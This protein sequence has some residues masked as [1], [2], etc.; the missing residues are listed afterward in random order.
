LF[1]NL[2]QRDF[3][4]YKL[5]LRI[6]LGPNYKIRLAGIMAWRLFLLLLGLGFC[7]SS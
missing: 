7:R 3:Q 5:S 6:A 1:A 2:K 4:D